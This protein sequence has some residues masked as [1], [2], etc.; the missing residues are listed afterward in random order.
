MRTLG[1]RMGDRLV[2]FLL[3]VSAGDDIVEEVSSRHWLL[4]WLVCVVLVDEGRD[5]PPVDVEERGSR[6][7]LAWLLARLVRW[8]GRHRW[9]STSAPCCMGP[10]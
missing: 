8:A 6:S 2:L 9:T 7:R 1:G 4:V 10:G 5:S 3:F